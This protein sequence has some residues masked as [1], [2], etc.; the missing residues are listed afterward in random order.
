MNR[1]HC[2][3]MPALVL[4]LA[5]IA[6]TQSQGEKLF[7]ENNPADAVQVLENEI[8][9]GIV[10]ENSYNFL[11]LGYYQL[12]EYEKSIKAF[13]RG[14]DVQP[15]NSKILS[16]NQGN[17]YFALKD[18]KAAVE[19]YSRA[20]AAEPD[21]SEALLNRANS[22]LMADQLRPARGDYTSYLEKNPE[23]AQKE[24]ISQLIAAIDEELARREEEERLARER[25]KAMW[26]EIDGRP[27]DG[28]YG[29]DGAEWERIDGDFIEGDY[30]PSGR[31]WETFEDDESTAIQNQDMEKIEEPADWEAVESAK[32]YEAVPY[33]YD[34]DEDK[35]FWESI[36]EKERELLKKLDAQG[37]EEYKRRKEALLK[38]ENSR[39]EEAQDSRRKRL[40]DLV[41][42]LQNTD[43]KNVSSGADDL[44]EYD[45]EGELD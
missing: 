19:C 35:E 27:E 3:M 24:R 28:F 15:G 41:N 8:S 4:F 12:G 34:K 36:D 44:I 39:L 37:V 32:E 26:E 20:L 25:E 5:G 1:K 11:G 31:A 10:S 14:L 43:V 29:A 7:K 9:N 21:F 33:E 23:D 40:D 30:K 22:L 45:M 18:Y 13:Q 2:L 6:F 16:Y 17:S 38:E 42:S